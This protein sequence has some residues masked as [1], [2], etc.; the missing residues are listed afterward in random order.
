MYSACKKEPFSN[1]PIPVLQLKSAQV[2]SSTDVSRDSIIILE[3]SYTDGDG[4]LGKPD[5]DTL[6]GP[7]F[8]IRFFEITNGNQTPYIIPLSNDT[9]NFNQYTPY[10]TPSGKDKSI[11]GE[12]TVRIPTSPYL[13][14]EPDSVL[15]V[16]T[17]EDRAGNQSNEVITP[18][19]TI[20]H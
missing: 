4:D 3:F 5:S 14:Y 7:N 20:R 17:L 2:I 6:S 12:I 15:F 8:F 11:K 13:G 9:L 19:L 18:V 16:A 10:L 1:S